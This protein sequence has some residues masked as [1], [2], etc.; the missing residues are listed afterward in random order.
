MA[1]LE[2]AAQR[3][4]KRWDRLKAD[5]GP[6][7]S[8]WQE[9]G[10]YLRPL[11]A[12]FTSM[13]SPG[14]KRYGKVFDSTPLLAAD[15]FAGGIYG[16]MTNP[17]NRWFSLRVEDD[18][19]NE[20][21]PVRD[22]LYD[23]E[24]RLLRSFGPQISGFYNVLP[25]LYADLAVFGT[26]IF[27]SEEIEGRP[28]I[29]DAQ[30]P[31][32]ECAISENA[33]GEVDTVYRR[34]FLE[35]RSA[36]AL[37]PDTISAKTKRVAEKDPFAKVFIL[38]CVEPNGEYDPERKLDQAKAKPY[39]S[40][41]V[42][43]EAKSELSRKGYFEFPY[44][45]PR[46]SQA[47]GEVYGRGLGETVLADVK[48]LNQQSRTS[49]VAAQKMADPPLAAPNEGVIRVA[50]TYP[51]GITYGAID[52]NGNMLLRPL[53][54]GGD[55]KL[56]LE[57][58]EQ[59]RQSIREGFYFSLMQMVGT[60]DMTATEWIGRQEEK[61]RLMGPNLGRIQSEFLSPLIKRRFGI[62]LRA[63][64]IPPPPPEISGA[65]LN[66]EYVSPLAKAQMASEAQSIVRL[67]QSLE[68]M[69]QAT[70]GQDVSVL[71]NIDQ[72][73]AARALARGYAVRPDIARD[74][75]EVE[76]IREGRQQQAAMAQGL[77]MG[78]QASKA[79]KNVAS[80]GKDV[81]AQQG[82]GGKTGGEGLMAAIDNIRQLL[83]KRA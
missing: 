37:W 78:E 31:L 13:R 70:G 47:A 51:G 11:R 68:V 60:P 25:G 22:W 8:L 62:L 15:N 81:A 30:R 44:Q 66:V 83:R 12:E 1:D 64:Q 32:A 46:W 4:A 41:Y 26:S 53:Y 77:Q 2:N 6:F 48:T 75:K 56:T 9:L 71:D 59:R 39:L 7:E 55:P 67:Y 79:F 61:L 40:I 14:E 34:F 57:M 36:I 20:F 45:V 72:D 21:E 28:R 49:L 69:I 19:L 63:R 5:R 18:D 50:R 27:Y 65:K 52:A 23:V 16:M 58:M 73:K 24:S 74:P 29:N 3:I 82:E 17:A 54:E 76:T 33:Y 10:D 80:G 38:H 35:A 42:E 43:E